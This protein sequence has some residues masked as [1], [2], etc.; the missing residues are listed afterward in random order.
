MGVTGLTYP[1]MVI[2]ILPGDRITITDMTPPNRTPG[3]SLEPGDISNTRD[4]SEL[5]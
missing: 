2:T 4:G 3:P 1:E 5:I